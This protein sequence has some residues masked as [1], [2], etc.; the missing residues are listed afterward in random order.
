MQPS[1]ASGIF[2]MLPPTGL[3]HLCPGLDLPSSY[4]SAVCSC[5]PPVLTPLESSGLGRHE[6]LSHL[7]ASVLFLLLFFNPCGCLLKKQKPGPQTHE[8][9]SPRVG[10]RPISFLTSSSCGYDSD[11]SLRDMKLNRS[12]CCSI[13]LFGGPFLV[14]ANKL[15][16]S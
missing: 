11:Q 6:G 7:P 16:T 3:L 1:A 5:R 10:L 2:C 15:E 9:E 14:S 4:F 12:V 13:Y 8:I